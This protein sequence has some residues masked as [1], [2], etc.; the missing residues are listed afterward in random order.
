MRGKEKNFTE[1]I[2]N[3]KNEMNTKLDTEVDDVAWKKANSNSEAAIR[4]VHNTVSSP[5]LDIHARRREVN[6]ILATIWY[7]ITELEEYMK[8]HRFL[9][10]WFGCHPR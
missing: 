9:K 2:T 3:F 7:D 1:G 10:Q 8:E 5:K 6:G 4:T